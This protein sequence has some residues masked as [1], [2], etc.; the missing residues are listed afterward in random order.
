[1]TRIG[2]KTM[3][4]LVVAGLLCAAGPALA[5]H[6]D[7]HHEHWHHHD[8]HYHERGH[9]HHHDEGYARYYYNGPSYYSDYGPQVYVPGPP[10][11]SF[12]LNLVFPVH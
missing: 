3:G 8:E 4:A 2:I 1:M 7:D 11:P 12:G 6:D 5:D 10:A 9:W